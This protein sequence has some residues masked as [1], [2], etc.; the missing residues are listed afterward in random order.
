MPAR[1]AAQ[2][3]EDARLIALHRQEEER[4]ARAQEAA[5]AREAERDS[6][7]SV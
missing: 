6:D 1:E 4:V 5:A 7:G 2:T 3:A